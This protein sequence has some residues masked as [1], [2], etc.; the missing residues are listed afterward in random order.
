MKLGLQVQLE[1]EYRIW[2][3]QKRVSVLRSRL[4]LYFLRPLVQYFA[5]HISQH[6]AVGVVSALGCPSPFIFQ[7]LHAPQSVHTSTKLILLFM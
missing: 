3:F 6:L 2:G 4:N 5:L 7:N 1:T